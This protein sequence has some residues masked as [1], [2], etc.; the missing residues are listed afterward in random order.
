MDT[1]GAPY[2]YL[3]TF[4]RGGEVP[5]LYQHLRSNVRYLSE[6]IITPDGQLAGEIFRLAREA[7]PNSRERVRGHKLL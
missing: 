5:E 1:L 3:V 6:Q 2:G 4:Y 7:M